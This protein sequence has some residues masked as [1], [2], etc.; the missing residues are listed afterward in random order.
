MQIVSASVLPL[1][2]K[3]AVELG[4]LDI[5]EKSGAGTLTT[6]DHDN[7]VHMVYALAPVATYFLPNREGGS[8]AP[9]LELIQHKTML[10]MWHHLKDAVLEGGLPFE[11][12]FGMNAVEY[13]GKDAKFC[14]IFKGSTRDFNPLFMQRILEIYKGFDGLKFLVDVGG[15]DGSLL[16]LIIS[17]YPA[18]IKAINYDLAP[19]IETFP[20]YPGIEHVVG[21]YIHAHS[22]S[23]SHFHEVDAPQL[24]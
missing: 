17:K 18:I 4:V 10:N 14:E 9:L 16:N 12:A 2:L 8:L 22:R 15:G 1:V 21:G 19:V 11:K 23:R 3:A 24:G 20:P 6:D 13:V 5:I 7:H